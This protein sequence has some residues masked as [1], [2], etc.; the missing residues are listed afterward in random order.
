MRPI[1]RQIGEIGRCEAL[2]LGAR[3]GRTTDL[4]EKSANP[5]RKAT[6]SGYCSTKDADRALELAESSLLATQQPA[7]DRKAATGVRTETLAG[8]E[9]RPDQP[10]GLLETTLHRR[11]HRPQRRRLPRIERMAA[12]A[13][14]TLEHAELPVDCRDVPELEQIGDQPDATADRELRTGAAAS[15]SMRRATARRAS[16]CSGAITRSAGPARRT[17]APR[18]P[19]TFGDLTASALSAP[20]SRRRHTIAPG[21]AAQGG[22]PGAAVGR[23]TERGQRLR[24]ADPRVASSA[25]VV[26]S[27]CPQKPIAARARSAA[28]PICA[29]Q[30]GRHPEARARGRSPRP[31]G[32]I[33]ESEQRTAARRAIVVAR[34]GRRVPP[35][36]GGRRPHS[37]GR[38]QTRPR[39]HVRPIAD[40]LRRGLGPAAAND[41]RPPPCHHGLAQLAASAARRAM[42]GLRARRARPQGVERSADQDVG[43][44]DRPG[45]VSPT[46]RI[47]VG[48]GE[49]R[50]ERRDGFGSRTR[51]RSRSEIAADDGGAAEQ[52]ARP[53]VEHA[54]NAGQWSRCTLGGKSADRQGNT[55]GASPSSHRTSSSTK[56]GLP[57]VRSKSPPACRGRAVLTDEVGHNTR[58]TSGSLKRARGSV[59]PSRGHPRQRTGPTGP[60]RHLLVTT[61]G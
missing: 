15:A 26:G 35:R 24:P 36:S 23:G 47:A 42:Q 18:H 52:V 3:I 31:A 21:R 32:G 46:S 19:G 33:P 44:A 49:H 51:R 38:L 54:P 20:R 60:G 1:V 13:R 4:A 25:V 12:L 55:S 43:E 22:E 39:R 14:L 56:S 6:I 8:G 57:S 27:P 45:S 17:R 41:G 34:R 16:R 28:S 58:P 10:I 29:G 5:E 53:V 30:R 59:R 48:V 61:G 7:L 9:R 2:E 37:R 11:A 50:V 40:S